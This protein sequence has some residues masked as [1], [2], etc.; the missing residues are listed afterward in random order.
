MLQGY[1]GISQTVATTA[2]HQYV[3]SF[4]ARSQAPTFSP[5]QHLSTNGHVSDSGGNGVDVLV[6]GAV[7][8]H[9]LETVR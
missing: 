4:Q 7:I 8:P 3:L 1:D 9:A 2:G 5:F 6:Y